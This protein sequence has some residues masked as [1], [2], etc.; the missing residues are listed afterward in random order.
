MIVKGNVGVG[1]T[2]PL[3][4]SVLD[5]RGMISANGHIPNG[6][7]F[8]ITSGCGTPTSLTG[9]ATTGSFKAGQTSCAP[10]IALPT[11]P[12]GW[13]CHGFDLTTTT[14][15]LKQTATSTTSC[16]ISGTVASS[17]NAALKK[18]WEEWEIPREADGKWPD[19]AKKLH[20]DWWA[21]RTA[22]QKEVDASIAAKAE[23]EYL[24]DKPY[25]DPKKVRVAGPFTVESLS[26]HR[27]LACIMQRR[28]VS[29][30]VGGAFW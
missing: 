1:T 5:A 11:A 3:N 20:A 10:I 17:L 26:P 4:S 18:T 29:A 27:V 9:G 21:A 6:T 22:R 8:T 30:S 16:T 2:S 28:D 7:T 19:G 14:D 23:F 24:Y 25:P 15:T 13:W 12:N